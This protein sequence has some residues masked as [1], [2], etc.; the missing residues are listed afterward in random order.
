MWE[1]RMLGNMMFKPLLISSMIEHAG[2]YHADSLVISKNTD[3][4]ITKTTWGDVHKNSKRFA[5]VLASLG[6]NLGDR[7]ATIAWNNH[8]HLESWYAI[9]GSGYV[10]HTINPRLFPEQLIFII[11]DAADRVML[12]DKTFLPLIKA[13]KPLLKSVEH[14]ICLDAPDAAIVEAVPDVNFMM[15]LSRAICRLYMAR[16]R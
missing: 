5:N 15:N 3:S 16:I 11:N 2:R 12:F 10:C 13:V 6:L 8:R 14:F 7:V 4:T 1:Q 9:S